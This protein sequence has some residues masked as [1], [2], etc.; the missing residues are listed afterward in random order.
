MRMLPESVNRDRP[1]ERMTSLKLKLAVLVGTSALAAA[2]VAA[3][4]DGAGVPMWASLPVTIAAALGIT[5]WLARGMTAPLDEMTVAAAAMAAGDYRAT[6]STS[7]ND[8]IGRLARSFSS[9]ASDLAEVD[10]QRRQLL[11][12]VSHELR[13]P[14]AAQ[15]ALLENL[16][17]GVSAPDPDVLRAALAQAERLSTLV[18]DLLDLSRID[19]GL[20]SLRLEQFAVGELLEQAVAEAEVGP[21]SV[22][23]EI[24]VDPPELQVRGDRAR[25]AQV[26]ANL[27]DNAGRHSPAGG[28]VRISAGLAGQDA[29]FLQVAD[30]GPG[31]TPQNAHALFQRFRGG[32]PVAGDSGLGLAIAGWVCHL[33]AGTIEALPPVPGE[34]GARVRA[35]LPRSPGEVAVSREEHNETVGSAGSGAESHPTSPAGPVTAVATVATMP[36]D[37]PPSTPGG[38]TPAS[39][40]PA[41]VLRPLPEA[42]FGTWWPER[43]SRPQQGLVA[44]S[45]AVGALA[46]ITLPWSYLGLGVFLVL[47]AGGWLVWSASPRR[48]EPWTLISAALALGLGALVV[49]RADE[50]PVVLA[51][52]LTGFLVVTALTDAWGVGSILA[53]AA[54]WVLAG[55]RGLPLLGSTLRAMSRRRLAWPIVRTAVISIVLVAFFGSLFAAADAVFGAWAATILPRWNLN[56]LT[57]RSFVGVVIGGV[58]LAG[59]YLALNPPRLSQRTARRSS[60]PV[61]AWEWQVPLTLVV[62]LFTAFIAAEGQGFFGGHEYLRR[63]TGLTYASYVHQGFGQLTVA[64]AATLALVAWVS[65]VAGRTQARDRL[66]LRLLLGALCLLTLLVVAS[67]LYRM[68]LYQQAFGFTMLRVLVDGFEAWLG[69]IVVFTMVAGLRLSGRWIPRAALVSAAVLLLGFGLANPGAWIASRNIERYHATG[70][71]DVAYLRSLGDDAVP[72]IAD[73]DL[74]LAARRCAI[75]ALTAGSATDGFFGWNL[76]RSRAR[77]IRASMGSAWTR[78]CLPALSPVGSTIPT[79]D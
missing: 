64:T 75:A 45:V 55:I 59:C 22:R 69:L 63:T 16:V 37:A 23:H 7:A 76:G 67:A 25:L 72:T 70:K 41:P 30:D 56:D 60:R 19:A 47:V 73:S 13:T 49:L 53:A 15:C 27:L 38:S 33:H 26:A 3:I 57:Y 43:D 8:E 31:L 20:A 32:E 68:N 58:V 6:V 21:R 35:I 65:R 40:N 5:W 54:A 34:T 79:P 74:P 77:E 39:A 66:A 11:A 29:W 1:L 42:L 44:G 50:V 18:A 9:M 62:L 52:M 61:R 14:L 12:T 36:A 78:Q 2:V 51:I 24:H 4:G 71:L 28:T 46:A 17:D 10:R 48:R